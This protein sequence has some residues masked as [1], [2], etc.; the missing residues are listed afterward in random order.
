MLDTDAWITLDGAV[1]ARDVA[2]IPTARGAVIA[3]RRLL[4]ADNL[5]DLSVGD[6]A[7]L[8][9]DYRL[10][11]VADLRTSVEVRG[12]GPGPLV[13]HGGV[14][15][16]HLS[17]FREPAQE[18]EVVETDDG[19]VVLPWQDDGEVDPD[20]A[21]HG[22]AGHYLGYLKTRPDSVLTALRMIAHP[23]GAT[24]V[25]CAAGKDRTGVVVALTLEAVGADRDA[26]VADYARSAERID[27]IIARLLASPTYHAD[28]AGTEAHVHAP[29]A[30][31]M[32][33]FLD[34]LDDR[35]GGVRGWL[36]SHGWTGADQDAL[37]HSLL[38]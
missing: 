9:G 4:R 37:E 32:A 26:V 6:I 34:L 18:V 20:E 15:I 21:E 7:L 23:D 5:Q 33:R 25:H 31:S 16:R 3:P 27:A 38:G 36:T 11:R 22:A 29:R 30:E 35:H 2:G 19:P 8:T 14:D 24:L 12:E 1:N 28:I 10:R 17:L 13:R